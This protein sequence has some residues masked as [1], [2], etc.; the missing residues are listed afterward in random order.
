MTSERLIAISTRD[1]ASWLTLSRPE[2]GNSLNVE[3]LNQLHSALGEI[4]TDQPLVL[5]G[6]GRAFSTGGDI[7]QCLQHAGDPEDLRD[8]ADRLVGALNRIMLALWDCPAP[9]LAAVN[10]PMTGGSLGFALVADRIIMARSAF[11]QPYYGAMGFAPD[12]GWTALLPTRVGSARARAW[13][14]GDDRQSA[15]ACLRLGLCDAV[16]DY[17]QLAGTLKTEIARMNALD[18][19]V[20]R[21]ARTLIGPD[22]DT[23]ARALEAEREAFVD[24]VAR[25]ETIARMRAFAASH[26][27]AGRA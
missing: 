10:G 18:P 7:L 4:P 16:V 24:L 23:L 6:A 26:A 8:Y 13:I 17:D 19:E 2:R 15:E 1:G 27:K 5:T 14:A 20:L 25:P 22:R 9:V 12:G 3:M 21:T 11:V